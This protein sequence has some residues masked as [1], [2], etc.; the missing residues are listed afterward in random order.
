MIKP[1][2][3]VWKVGNFIQLY[4]VNDPLAFN[5]LLGR[6][7]YGS[8][9]KAE[10]YVDDIQFMNVYGS[11]IPVVMLDKTRCLRRFKRSDYDDKGVSLSCLRVVARRLP[12][13]LYGP[14]KSL[15]L[16]Q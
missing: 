2:S 13:L 9:S 5:D 4:P 10:A 7:I 1:S 6:K 16:P 11:S 14:V 3:S 15:R 8:L 12:H